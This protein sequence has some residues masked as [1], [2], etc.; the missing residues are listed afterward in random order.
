MSYKINYLSFNKQTGG[1]GN[2]VIHISGPQGSG[3]TTIGNE[4]KEMYK[5]KIHV[6]DFDDLY[7]DFN[8][9]KTIN[10]YQ[11]FIDKFIVDHKDKPLILVG[12]D[13]DLCLGPIENPQ[14]EGYKIDT[15]Y[16]Y[17][18]KIDIETN[19]KQW[20]FRQI[21]KL[22]SRKEMFY[23]N[24]I[25]DNKKTQEKLFRFVDLNEIKKN[26]KEC[27]ELYKTKG[28]RFMDYKKILKKCKTIL[29]EIVK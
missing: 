3:K 16:K 8:Q 4:L 20:F 21:N 18:I 19:L 9:Q 25:K 23:D 17:Y 15:S 12:L 10:S 13:A 1:V 5:D 2:V 26:K 7:S 27:D 29:D 11:K 28:Y 22:N 24:W 6:K 14:L